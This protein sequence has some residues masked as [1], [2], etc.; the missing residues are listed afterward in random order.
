M[1]RNYYSVP[2][3]SIKRSMNGPSTRVSGQLSSG[4]S[5]GTPSKTVAKYEEMRLE[6]IAAKAETKK[7]Q[8]KKRAEKKR[9]L[10]AARKKEAEKHQK[11]KK[12]PAGYKLY[13]AAYI[14]AKTPNKIN[15]KKV[16]QKHKM[17]L[18]QIKRLFAIFT[19]LVNGK[20][21]HIGPP[22]EKIDGIVQFILDKGTEEDVKNMLNSLSG[23]LILM[24][25]YDNHKKRLED[26]AHEYQTEIRPIFTEKQV[27]EKKD[28][29]KK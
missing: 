16:S 7:R 17:N 8:A 9:A 1:A 23:Y 26:I 3:K 18:G 12:N 22:D 13:K 28:L 25:T 4:V 2:S 6:R 5:R 14:K 27:R 21:L 20:D 10:K 24:K 19:S 15:A 29:F 11:I